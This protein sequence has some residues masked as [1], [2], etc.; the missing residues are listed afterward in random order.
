MKQFEKAEIWFIKQQSEG[1]TVFLQPNGSDFVIP[2]FIDHLEF[3]IITACTGKKDTMRPLTQDLF[4]GFIEKCGLQVLR[5]ELE[6]KAR[7]F[8]ARLLITGSTGS[9]DYTETAPLVVDARPSDA[10]ALAIR[11]N[12]PIYIPARLIDKIGIPMTYIV[13]HGGGD[14]HVLYDYNCGSPFSWNE[15]SGMKIDMEINM[16]DLQSEIQEG[17]MTEQ[18]RLYQELNK[19]IEL[20]EYERAA[21]IRDKLNLLN[22]DPS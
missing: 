2:I 5:V 8:Y 3:Q 1:G 21:E 17:P 19:A 13:N 6:T 22:G 16:N 10:L 11:G 18:R 4:L 7:I 9:M 20:E 15:E 12:H 14:D